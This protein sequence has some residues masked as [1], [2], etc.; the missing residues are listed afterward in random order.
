MHQT[1]IKIAKKRFEII[2]KNQHSH[3]NH[4]FKSKKFK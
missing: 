2:I 3:L 4:D 1:K